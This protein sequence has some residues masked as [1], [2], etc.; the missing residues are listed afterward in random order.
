MK[1][2]FFLYGEK[3]T[4]ETARKFWNILDIPNLDIVIHTPDTTSDYLGS[5]D[6]QNVTEN[7]FNILG[8]P[9]VFLHNR[10]DFKKEINRSTHYSWKFLSKYLNQSNVFYDFIFVCRLDSTFY[11]EDWESISKN[12]ENRIFLTGRAKGNDFIQDHVFFGNYN[13]IK[14]FVD[15][16]PIIGID[17]NPHYQMCRYIENNFEEKDWYNFHSIHIRNN[18]VRY[19]ELYIDKYKKIKN[20][21]ANY[22]NFIKN[23]FCEKY[24]YKLDIE[25]KKSYRKDWI[26]D[27]QFED[28]ELEKM[29]LEFSQNL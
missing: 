5:T 11:V 13:V 4:F 2:L 26:K 1:C 16:F 3:R 22:L 27:Y 21:D 18:M 15:N 6:F 17:D 19:F 10:N 24:E 28:N 8:N 14:N 29:F 23:I 20:I 9:K 25:Y 7:D 12:K